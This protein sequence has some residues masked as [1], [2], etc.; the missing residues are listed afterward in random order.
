MMKK[1]SLFYM[2]AMLVLVAC[3]DGD[4]T[5]KA[6]DVEVVRFEKELFSM[7]VYAP[8]AKTK[9]L[10]KKYPHFMPLYTN[11]VI[12]IGDTIRPYVTDG[13]AAFVTD[14]AMYELF[15]S[16]DSVFEDFSACEAT[17]AEGLGRFQEHFPEKQIPVVY[18]YVSGLNQT[19][20]VGDGVL[21]I[22]LDKY[23][24]A[25]NELYTKVYPPIPQYLKSNMEPAY[26]GVDAVRAWVSSEINYT[27]IKDNLLSKMLNEA[28][29]LYVTRQVL[30]NVSDT[31]LW[32]FSGEQLRF[33]VDNEAE[34]W[35]YLIQQKLLFSTDYMVINKLVEPGPFTKDFTRDSPARAVVWVGY[36]IIDAYMQ[37][38]NKLTLSELIK[39]VDYQRILNESR[40]NP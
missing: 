15:N 30:P 6:V 19:L 35:K 22:S 9:E 38:N 34:M 28:M 4:T 5:S 16:V 31:L 29:A 24:G 23:L 36:Q 39:E 8:E 12:N 20:V 7:D 18:T 1:F 26:V 10:L 3:G 27:P 2:C 21:G 25:N 14:L 37:R 17:I 32:G 13:L 40:Y 33:C 11:R